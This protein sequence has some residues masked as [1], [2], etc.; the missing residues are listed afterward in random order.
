MHNGSTN[1]GYL[2]GYIFQ[3]GKT[4][5]LDGAYYSEQHYDWYYNYVLSRALLPWDP[6]GTQ[7]LSMY[8]SSAYNTNSGNK[9][10]VDIANKLQN[11]T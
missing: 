10:Y 4:Y 9:Y 2:T 6:S 5:G 7:S 8:I 1:H 11:L 3:T